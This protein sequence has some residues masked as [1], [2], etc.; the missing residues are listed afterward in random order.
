MNWPLL[1]SRYPKAILTDET[2]LTILVVIEREGLLTEEDITA[3]SGI[4][5]NNVSQQIYRLQLDG[6]VEHG[7]AHVR[8]TDR[9]RFLIDR[10]DLTETIL[11]DAL[12]S[13]EPDAVRRRALSRV[14]RLYRKESPVLFQNSLCTMRV[15]G[16]MLKSLLSTTEAHITEDE[17]HGCS[18]SFLL[19][20][21]R[22]WCLHQPRETSF[23]ADIE[24]NLRNL[25][26]SHLV[27]ADDCLDT[28]NVRHN[29]SVYYLTMLDDSVS[30]GPTLQET[31][32]RMRLRNLV[33]HFHVA[34]CAY[35]PFSWYET[36]LAARTKPVPPRR[37][38]ALESAI[39]SAV[40]SLVEALPAAT[41]FK[42]ALEATALFRRRW[43]ADDFRYVPSDDLM[44][45]ILASTNID[46]FCESANLDHQTALV[47][48]NAVKDRCGNLIESANKRVV[49]TGDPRTGHRPEQP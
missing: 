48:L 28:R 47:L 17:V 41:L 36:L 25:L 44:Q 39:A 18:K 34:Q 22:N 29:F 32:S 21:L 49:R 7:G 45:H 10:F 6:L 12:S 20:D 8:L 30:T 43:D 37:H 3:K 23:L 31:V 40:N 16:T 26:A 15:W 1:L 5:R 14:M 11:D 4:D 27:K 13:L 42:N 9:G 19:R 46:V 2:A 24:E 38:S 33:E 35:E